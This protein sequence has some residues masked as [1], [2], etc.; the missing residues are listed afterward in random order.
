MR[1]DFLANRWRNSAIGVCMV[2][3][4]GGGLFWYF[5]SD[6][7]KRVNS[8]SSVSINWKRRLESDFGIPEAALQGKKVLLHVWASWCPPCVEE[9]PRFRRF[10]ESSKFPPSSVAVAISLDEKKQEAMALLPG[11]TGGGGNFFLVFDPAHRFSQALGSF[12]FPETFL[13]E[14]SGEW[15]RKWV[16]PQDWENLKLDALGAQRN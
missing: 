16:G 2:G 9:I 15:S 13:I 8:S 11:L 1:R 3:V 10:I 12:Q 6:G 4:L 5:S 14:E 7:S